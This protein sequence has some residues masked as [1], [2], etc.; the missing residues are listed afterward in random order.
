MNSW[1]GIYTG[2]TTIYSCLNI[3]SNSL[4]KVEFAERREDDPKYVVGIKEIA[5]FYIEYENFFYFDH[6]L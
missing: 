6:H 5:L 3:N 1:L 4:D 2:S